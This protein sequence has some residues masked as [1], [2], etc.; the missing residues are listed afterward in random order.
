MLKVGI[1]IVSWA[2]GGFRLVR[3]GLRVSCGFN[4]GL[5]TAWVNFVG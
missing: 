2:Y 5:G 3:L 1:G 4:V